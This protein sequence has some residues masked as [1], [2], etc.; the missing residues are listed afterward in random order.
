MRLIPERSNISGLS[1]NQQLTA[2]GQVSYIT[3][4]V[5]FTQVNNIS[6]FVVDLYLD[7]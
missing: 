2:S 6:E 5:P 1:Q 4:P 3:I 7:T